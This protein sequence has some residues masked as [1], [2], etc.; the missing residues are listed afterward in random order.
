MESWANSLVVAVVSCGT[1][2][3]IIML[4]LLPVWPTQCALLLLWPTAV[5]GGA[6]SAAHGIGRSGPCPPPLK[7]PPRTRQPDHLWGLVKGQE[8][9]RLSTKL[10]KN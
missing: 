5:S 6:G 1:P 10:T 2:P 7:H 8:S 9:C 3:I 4:P